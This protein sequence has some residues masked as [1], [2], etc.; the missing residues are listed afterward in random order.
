MLVDCIDDESSVS[1]SL[2]FIMYYGYR[3]IRIATEL[4]LCVRGNAQRDVKS[5]QATAV[6]SR[7]RVIYSQERVS[8]T[9]FATHRFIRFVV[10]DL[11]R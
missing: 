9:T 7:Q 10:A 2:A 4:D 11:K 3:Y 6:D 1:S 5:W 8:R